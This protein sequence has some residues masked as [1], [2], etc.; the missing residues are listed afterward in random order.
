MLPQAAVAA[1]MVQLL[2]ANDAWVDPNLR[3]LI[4]ETKEKKLPRKEMS[5]RPAK[6]PS[7]P[8]KKVTKSKTAFARTDDDKDAL[9]SDNDQDFD[10]LA[11]NRIVLKRASHVSDASESDSSSD[12]D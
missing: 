6:N 3:A 2:E 5:S 10:D 4:S 9:E 7:K 12:E 8:D 11:P 1:D